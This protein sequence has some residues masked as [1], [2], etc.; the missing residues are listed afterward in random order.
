MFDLKGHFFHGFYRRK[1]TRTKLE[2]M[3]R[4][5]DC[6]TEFYWVFHHTSNEEARSQT[7]TSQW[8]SDWVVIRFWTGLKGDADD[9]G[10][11][12]ED[13]QEETI[14]FSIDI[15]FPPSECSRLRLP[16]F[17]CP[18]TSTVRSLRFKKK[19]FL[20]STSFFFAFF[21]FPSPFFI[22]S[23]PIF[24]FVRFFFGCYFWFD[25]LHWLIGPQWKGGAGSD[26]PK[27]PSLASDSP[28][29]SSILASIARQVQT[30]RETIL[31]Q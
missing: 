15:H 13:F 29:I 5:W 2:A 12:Q 24:L 31:G 20:L 8:Y 26:K 3:T 18:T 23:V 9:G 19:F 27:L 10:T 11:N 6:F 28:R 21:S 16:V 1:C 30:S 14:R 22:Q 4:S 25:R 7:R 17:Q